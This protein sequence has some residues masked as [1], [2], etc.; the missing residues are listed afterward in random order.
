LAAIL[1]VVEERVV[2]NDYTLRYQGK[3]YQIARADLGGGLRGAKLR[4]EKH[5]DGSVAVRFRGRYLA[6][7]VCAPP[8]P[9]KPVWLKVRA[10]KNSLPSS[11]PGSRRWMEGFSLKHSPPLWKILKHEAGDVGRQ[12]ASR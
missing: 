12:E 5:L 10:Q 8:P 7:S 3:I 11:R 9:P 4:V 2:T 1:S 6:A